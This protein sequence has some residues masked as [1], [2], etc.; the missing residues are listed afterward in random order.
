M[1]SPSSKLNLA[2]FSL[3][4]NSLQDPTV[5]TLCGHSSIY[6]YYLNMATVSWHGALVL[7]HR[8]V[9]FNAVAMADL[10]QEVGLQPGYLECRNPGLWVVIIAQRALKLMSGRSTAAMSVGD[11]GWLLQRLWLAVGL[12]RYDGDGDGDDVDGWLGVMVCSAHEITRMPWFLSAHACDIFPFCFLVSWTQMS[13]NSR[14][15]T[16]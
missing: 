12:S 8:Y 1:A 5:Q 6:Y 3:D 11:R 4:W 7:F 15:T 14:H 16:C 13:C 2:S 9:Y 10:A